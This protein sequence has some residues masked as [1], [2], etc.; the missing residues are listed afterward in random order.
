M[1]QILDI[2]DL[3]AWYEREFNA[4]DS[5]MTPDRS[6]KRNVDGAGDEFAQRRFAYNVGWLYGE[7][8]DV[9]AADGYGAYVMRKE[10]PRVGE[11]TC[12]EIH[13]KALDSMRKNLRGVPGI[14]ITKG[15][16]EDIPFVDDSFDSVYCGCTLEHVANDA[17]VV[18]EIWR[19][20]RDL[21]VFYV[22]IQGKL[23]RQHVRR[24]ESVADFKRLIHRCFHIQHLE[25]RQRDKNQGT[26]RVSVTIVGRKRKHWA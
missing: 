15:I 12:L 1:M 4:P 14:T 17:Q 11:I 5:L 21:A 8:L 9:G 2:R 18:R 10:N 23:N 7:V 6:W 16:G 13:N 26:D 24:Y 19:V 20:T 3:T 22:P 25:E